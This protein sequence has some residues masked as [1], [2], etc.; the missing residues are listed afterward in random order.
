[1]KTFYWI[2]GAGILVGLLIAPDKG[3]NTRS[4]LSR[5]TRA[6]KEKIDNMRS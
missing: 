4:K 3:R 1:M 2:F 6:I 5:Q